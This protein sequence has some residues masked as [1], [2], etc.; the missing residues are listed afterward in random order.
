MVLILRDRRLEVKQ[1]SYCC[2]S[3][4]LT[5]TQISRKGVFAFR[6]GPELPTIGDLFNTTCTDTDF[7]VDLSTEIQDI[8]VCGIVFLY[9]QLGFNYYSKYL[10]NLAFLFGFLSLTLSHEFS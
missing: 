7:Y 8:R 6:I 2:F 3:L 10:L 4:S 5:N 1:T 9:S